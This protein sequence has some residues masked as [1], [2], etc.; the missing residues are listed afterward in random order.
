[1]AITS[2]AARLADPRLV[3]SVPAGLRGDAAVAWV[4]SRQYGVI[5]GDQLYACGLSRSA[6]AHR[7]RTGRLHRLHPRVFAVGRADVPPEGLVLAGVLAA[8]PSAVA[9][10]WSAAL[11]LDVL[12]AGTTPGTGLDPVDVTRTDGAHARSPGGLRCHET[13]LFEPR[14]LRWRGP[15]P[16]TSGARTA[17]DLAAT[18]GSRTAERV[19]AE[20]LRARRTS[21]TEVRSLVSRAR[22]H[23][24]VGVLARLIDAGPAFDRSVAERLLLELLRRAG[25]PEPKTNARL[26]GWEVDA[27]W[28]ALSVVVEFDS[29]TFHGDVLAFR[30][31]RRKSADLQARGY[32]VVPVTWSDLHDAPEVVV[33]NVSAVL[34]TARARRG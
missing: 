16:V 2:G 18:A 11:L 33:A 24:G 12:P 1:M 31:D 34:A 14:D 26:A 20:A 17:L 29:W 8:G 15:V 32:A 7:L 22:G 6:I 3:V 28:P 23:H 19:L 9:S 10:H 30:K 25:L 5:A 21:E 4:A 27:L 13:R